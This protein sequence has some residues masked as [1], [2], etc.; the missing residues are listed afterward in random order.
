[1]IS[2][3]NPDSED[4]PTDVS[5]TDNPAIKTIETT[6]TGNR[7]SWW[8][9]FRTHR[10]AWAGVGIPLV[11]WG[12]AMLTSA[13]AVKGFPHDDNFN[14]L[15]HDGLLFI[16]L[17]V[18]LLVLLGIAIVMFHLVGVAKANWLKVVA[19]LGGIGVLL[20]TA[21]V[22]FWA[23]LVVIF[24]GRGPSLSDTVCPPNRYCDYTSPFD[25]NDGYVAVYRE[26]LIFR[27][28]EERLDPFGH[29]TPRPSQTPEN[30]KPTP[31]TSSVPAP[32]QQSSPPNGIS[33][34]PRGIELTRQ[35]FPPSCEVPNTDYAVIVF[36]KAGPA[37]FNVSVR[38]EG[39]SWKQIVN[40]PDTGACVEA[41]SDPGTGEIALTFQ[42][43][44]GVKTSWTSRDAGKTWN[45]SGVQ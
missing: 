44:N 5:K 4:E 16:D 7:P 10:G 40:L 37:N 36:D 35:E 39:K 23:F 42:D 27:H 24:L 21:L 26:G 1:M 45:Q 41:T 33:Q 14:W 31:E 18:P 15:V 25:P 22:S 19:A 29:D 6:G 30:P 2:S 34:E 38:A 3:E 32:G 8:R 17:A 13:F 11:V 12:L 28:Y 43:T 20:L 9:W